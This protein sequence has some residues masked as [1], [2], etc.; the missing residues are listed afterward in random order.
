MNY[1]PTIILSVIF[2]AGCVTSRPDPQ[3]SIPVT[4]VPYTIE[5]SSQVEINDP[6]FVTR[7]PFGSY[8]SYPVKKWLESGLDDWAKSKGTGAEPLLVT[9]GILSLQTDYEGIGQIIPLG[10]IGSR[11]DPPDLPEQATKSALLMMQVKVS[12]GGREL[13]SETLQREFVQQLKYDNLSPLSLYNDQLI[14]YRPVLEGIILKVLQAV[15]EKIDQA[16]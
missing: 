13:L 1:F 5:L 4:S 14:D 6:F 2:L 11:G 12:N 10:S 9:V 16:L 15:D 3:L 7:G 8:K